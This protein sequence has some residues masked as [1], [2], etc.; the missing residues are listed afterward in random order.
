[1]QNNFKVYTASAGAGKTYQLVKEYLIKCFLSNEKLPFSKILAITFTNKASAEMKVRV[2]QKLKLFSQGKDECFLKEISNE[3]KIS[4]K[5]LQKKSKTLLFSIL[6]NYSNFWIGT[7]DKFT[8]QVARSFSKELGISLNAEL[9]LDQ[10]KTT[11]KSID[12][13]LSKVG[14][15]ESLTKSLVKYI[16]HKTD[17]G[18]SWQIELEIKNIAKHVNKEHS[19]LFIEDLSKINS[20]QFQDIKNSLTSIINLFNNNVIRHAKHANNKLVFLEIQP[21]SFSRSC[22]P[23][24]YKKI[25]QSNHLTQDDLKIN[26]TLNQRIEREKPLYAKKVSDNQKK[27]IDDNKEKIFNDFNLLQDYIQK[28]KSEYFLAVI[29]NKNIYSLA[30]LKKLMLEKKQYKSNNN[31]VELSEF[32]RKI[33][34]V[35]KCEPTPFLYEK[36]GERFNHFLIDEFQDTSR[37]QWENL[38]PLI[39]N[40]IANTNESCSVFG[41]G[42]QSVYRW[43][44]SNV[45]QFLH[46]ANSQKRTIEKSN[47]ETI[48]K[49]IINLKFNWRSD[50]NIITFNNE[51]FNACVRLVQNP[52]SKR[53]YEKSSQKI[54]PTKNK[55]KGWIRIEYLNSKN[56]IKENLDKTLSTVKDLE[57]KC[58]LKDI[59]IIVR[60]NKHARFIA[61]HL[62]SNNI[63]VISPD[64]LLLINNKKVNIVI[65]IL[66]L[67]INKDNQ[68]SKNNILSYFKINYNLNLTKKS[69]IPLT[70][71]L[72]EQGIDLNFEQISK[73]PVFESVNEII[74]KFK[75][76]SCDDSYL[77]SL[78]EVTHLFQIKNS[79]SIV[80]FLN[81]WDE[82]YLKQTIKIPE[83]VN[84]IKI[85]TIHKAKGLEFP[86]VIFPFANWEVN[87]EP[88]SPKDWVWLNNEF[89][90]LPTALINMEKTVEETNYNS[91]FY[92]YKNNVELDNLNLLYVTL[93]RAVNALYVFT[94]NKNENNLNKYFNNYL[95]A[96]NAFN[97]DKTFYS[98]GKIHTINTNSKKGNIKKLAHF[99]SAIQWRNLKI[100]H[101]FESEWDINSIDESANWGLFVHK[102][103]ELL[104]GKKTINS[105]VKELIISQIL[106]K[107]NADKI[108]KWLKSAIEIKQ[109]KKYFFNSNTFAEKEILLKDGSSFR[110]DRILIN[111]N[112]A[113]ILDFKTG[114]KHPSHFNQLDNYEIAVNQM[115]YNV[116]EKAILYLNNFEFVSNW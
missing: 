15:D 9:E 88:N 7:I 38:I 103:L 61:K 46:L 14:L 99:T 109:V 29:I 42:K 4:K 54:P 16:Q 76:S 92:R 64:S 13:L 78:C 89:P 37:L 18:K 24:Y 10:E 67:L 3:T 53:L 90:P 59:A 36:I 58:Q 56:W 62:S 87:K 94:S 35:V 98:L 107:K 116:K 63:N 96:I 77:Q 84:A 34:N 91:I 112:D 82:N 25:I 30:I 41:D 80:D 50:Y 2:L 8:Y 79:V 111:D 115:G 6:H 86:I 40:S 68:I 39:S 83:D 104:N 55:K 85:L 23:S 110:P 102:A 28:N 95:S 72:K 21:T 97:K 5:T 1:M 49:Q 44:N 106:P 105:V 45:N 74:N 43:R 19:N 101:S 114:K 52:I 73:L 17:D 31:I 22:L 108:T 100:A 71:S 51:F 33:N 48:N 75:W 57:K 81:W 60:K 20:Q 70:E 27:I 69:S 12:I 66:K 32:N 47:R 113:Y 11:N 26:K 93:T 65:D